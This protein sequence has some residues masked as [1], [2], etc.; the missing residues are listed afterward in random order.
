MS[1]RF[2]CLLVTLLFLLAACSDG[3]L[4]PTL[5]PSDTPQESSPP[6]AAT[7]TPSPE[8]TTTPTITPTPSPTPPYPL[9]GM[10]PDDFPESVNP[11]TGQYVSDAE[12]LQRRPVAVKINI[13]PRLGTRPPWGLS[14]ADIVYE[15]YQNAG[16]TRFH[17][18]F[19]GKDAP[20]AGSIRSA[21]M[22]DG[23]LVNM[24]QTIFAYAGADAIIDSTLRDSPFGYRLVRE[25]GDRAEC[26]PTA[27][28]PMCRIEPDSYDFLLTGT[29]EIHQYAREKGIDDVAQDLSGLFFHLDPPEGGLPAAEITTR[30]SIDSYNQWQYDPA[31]ERYLR[32]QDDET[33]F[34]DQQE[35]YAPL[36]DRVNDEQIAAENVVILFVTH[37]FLREPPGEIIEILLEGKG[38]AYAFRDG[39][40]YQ[41]EWNRRVPNRVMYL[42]FEDGERYPLKPGVTFYQIIGQYSE[43][44]QPEE[45]SWRFRFLFP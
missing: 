11:L 21:R 33:L 14:F 5:A 35:E 30:V 7:E 19:L 29:H 23:P 38:K 26:P 31:S 16:Y 36:I 18:I 13:V 22:F 17:A 40:A 37:E 20:L 4:S 10:G 9:E 28:Q 3:D 32:F 44:T 1:R 24:Y 25:V 41:V 34:G 39:L 8:P 27:E 12:L 43:V 15:F 2:N 45:D 6:L 42:T